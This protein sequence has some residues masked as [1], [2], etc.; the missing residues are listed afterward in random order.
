MAS[1]QNLTTS[2]T[3]LEITPPNEP[4]TLPNSGDASSSHTRQSS[5]H[6]QLRSSSSEIE[7]S[8]LSRNTPARNPTSAQ[9]SQFVPGNDVA[10]RGDLPQSVS[11]APSVE[12]SSMPPGS[13][14]VISISAKACYQWLQ[15]ILGIMTLVLGLVSIL[16]YNVRS[17]RLAIW[18]ARND[19][20]QACTGMIQVSQCCEAKNDSAKAAN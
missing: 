16:V 14:N 12:V 2:I 19:E 1:Q 15:S 18:T 7:L 6:S 3:T 5:S 17:Y 20:I 10:I 8:E 9:P 11:P 4:R 13:T